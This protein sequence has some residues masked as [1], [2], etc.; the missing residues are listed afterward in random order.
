MANDV[1]NSEPINGWAQWS[2]Y[3]LASIKEIKELRE[4]VI[5]FKVELAVLK[6]KVAF[7]GGFGAVVGTAVGTLIV[8]LVLYLIKEQ[9]P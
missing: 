7:W 5:Q 3:V 2:R 6:I 8:Q 1:N 9:K 4:V